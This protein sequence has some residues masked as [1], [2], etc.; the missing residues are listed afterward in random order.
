MD[1]LFFSVSGKHEIRAIVSQD[2]DVRKGI[3]GLVSRRKSWHKACTMNSETWCTL[4]E[5]TV[6]LGGADHVASQSQA[7]KLFYGFVCG[8]LF[9]PIYI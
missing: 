1:F 4:D 5:P 7:Q 2:S 8:F 9:Y 3:D 6:T